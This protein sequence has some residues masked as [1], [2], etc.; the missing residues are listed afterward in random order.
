MAFVTKSLPKQFVPLVGEQDLFE[1]TLQRVKDDLFQAPVVVASEAHR[2]HVLKQ[3]AGQD[4]QC[5]ILL[6]P[7]GRNTAP[8][9]IM[10]ALHLKSQGHDGQ[11]LILPSDHLMPDVVQFADA[12]RLGLPAALDDMLVTFGISPTGPETGYGYIQTANAGP[13]L[14][15]VSAFHEKPDRERAEHMLATGQYFWNAG[16]FLIGVNRLLSLAERHQ[17]DML[18]AVQNAVADMAKDGAFI[19]RMLRRGTRCHPSQLTT[20]WSKN[21]KALPVYHMRDNGLTWVTG[22]LSLLLTGL[23]KMGTAFGAE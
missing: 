18:L 6:E 22:I 1:L 13:G 2:F 16:I 21:V 23:I 14:C 12:V 17:P 7:S 20:H 15:N 9:I 11:M 8:A 3:A 19:A 5:E 4:M 10:A